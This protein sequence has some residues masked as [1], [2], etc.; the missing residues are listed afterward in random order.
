MALCASAVLLVLGTHPVEAQLPDVP[1]GDFVFSSGDRVRVSVWPDSSLGGVFPIEKSGVVHLP[2]LGARTAAGKSVSE[3]R[4]ELRL[5]YAE[6][7]QLPV[8]SLEAHF[9]VSILG[10]VRAS[11]VYWVDPS[12]GIFDLLS[13]AGGFTDRAEEDRMVITRR[14][15]E[16]YRI[17]AERLQVPG[18]GESL[19]ALRSG[20][21]LV[22]PERGRFNWGIFLQTLTLAVT[23]TSVITR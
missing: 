20:D 13:E 3:F 4:E 2:L 15:G 23:L 21:R 16:S 7:L 9:R 22:V 12:Y 14:S 8:V 10:A 5:G 6:D 19:I 18:T 11:G 17:D 1:G